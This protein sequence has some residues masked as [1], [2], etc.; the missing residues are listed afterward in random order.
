VAGFPAGETV[1]LL[2]PGATTQDGY[3]NDVPGPDVETDIEGVAVSPR[4][5]NASSGNENTQGRDQV[6]SGFVIWLPAGTEMRPTDRVRV[7]GV[8]CE[9]DGEDG[10]WRSPF[11]GLSSPVQVSLKRVTG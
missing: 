10:Q 11:T 2:R 3:G 1:T 8:V 5:G 9:V 7:R 6:I 4:D